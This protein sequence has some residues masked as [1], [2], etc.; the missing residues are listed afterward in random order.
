LETKKHPLHPKFY[1]L[2]V[3]LLCRRTRR[4]RYGR[5]CRT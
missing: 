5:C 2:R 3:V 1:E 4:W